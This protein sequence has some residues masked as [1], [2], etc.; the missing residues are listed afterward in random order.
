MKIKEIQLETLAQEIQNYFDEK[1]VFAKV[2][3]HHKYGKYSYYIRVGRDE[4]YREYWT[5]FHT[6]NVTFSL[7][8]FNKEIIS[9]L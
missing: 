9:L 4:S 5:G 6:K 3:P 2:E 8:K 1:G 7:L